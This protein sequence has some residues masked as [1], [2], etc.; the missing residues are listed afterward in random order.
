VLDQVVAA[1]PAWQRGMLAR[2]GRI[3]L[4][5]SAVMARSIH[6]LFVAD[7]SVAGSASWRGS[8]CASRLALVP[9]ESKT[10]APGDG[11]E[12]HI[13]RWEWL[14]RTDAARPWQGLRMMFS[15]VQIRF[16]LGRYFGPID[17]SGAN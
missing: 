7:R 6:H 16:R 11:F 15:T 9:W 5:K 8:R 12:G 13:L 17:G 14:R 4:I 10:A 1:L 2:S 3:T